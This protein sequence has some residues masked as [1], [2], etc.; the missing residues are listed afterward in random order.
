MGRQLSVV[1]TS[2][3]GGTIGLVLGVL[4]LVI[5]F[6]TFPG[7]PGILEL[8]I[9]FAGITLVLILPGA[10]IG[11]IVGLAINSQAKTR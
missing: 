11:A 3:V 9:L 4:G 5:L 2:M 6:L 1:F 8:L 7:M 10:I